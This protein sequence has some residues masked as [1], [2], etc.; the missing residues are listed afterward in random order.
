MR[1]VDS[2]RGG[3]G[4]AYGGS[5]QRRLCRTGCSHPPEPCLH[6]RPAAGRC[7]PPPPPTMQAHLFA[8]GRRWD[9]SHLKRQRRAAAPSA[10]AARGRSCLQPATPGAERGP[11]VARL[12]RRWRG[13]T[14]LQRCRGCEAADPAPVCQAAAR[15]CVPVGNP[16]QL[17]TQAAS[18]QVSKTKPTEPRFL[19]SSP[20]GGLDP[21]TDRRRSGL[22]LRP[23]R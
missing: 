14:L 1:N 10:P 5:P 4:A 20:S 6:G 19:K 11:L 23:R 21:Q 17:A 18:W 2:K 3:Q 22:H 9:A 12:R 8:L 15:A 13:L 16:R 7:S